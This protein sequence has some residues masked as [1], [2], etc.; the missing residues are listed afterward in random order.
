MFSGDPSTAAPQAEGCTSAGF[1][2]RTQAPPILIASRGLSDDDPGS[3]SGHAPFPDL[4]Q[5]VTNSEPFSNST[6]FFNKIPEVFGVTADCQAWF[7]VPTADRLYH[8]PAR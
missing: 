1:S 6:G 7:T 3:P 4:N 5:I 2:T 8:F